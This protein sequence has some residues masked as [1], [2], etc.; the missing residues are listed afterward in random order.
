[1]SQVRTVPLPWT[2]LTTAQSSSDEFHPSGGYMSAAAVA[3]VRSVWE[4]KQRTGNMS[5][6]PGFELSNSEDDPSPIV[7]KVGTLQTSKAIQYPSDWQSMAA[8]TAGK[9]LIRPGWVVRNTAGTDLS[10]ARVGGK[11]EIQ[12]C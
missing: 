3:S 4:L 6:T 5:V 12:T 7:V 2:T 10:T 11:V 8:N 1:M 9:Q